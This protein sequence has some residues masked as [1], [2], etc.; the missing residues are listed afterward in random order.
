M[1]LFE[2]ESGYRGGVYLRGSVDGLEEV[3]VQANFEDEDGYLVE[4]DF[5]DVRTLVYVT[6]D[7]ESSALP[8]LVNLGIY[9][10]RVEEL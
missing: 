2:H 3:I 7:F 5:A 4:A 10:L 8:D 1:S 6:Q 9:V